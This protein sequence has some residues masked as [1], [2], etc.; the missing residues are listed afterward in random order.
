[1]CTLSA[2]GDDFFK[3]VEQIGHSH[4]GRKLLHPLTDNFQVGAGMSVEQ[5]FDIFI[6][7]LTPPQLEVS[8]AQLFKT[9]TV[10]FWSEQ[11]RDLGVGVQRLNSLSGVRAASL[12]DPEAARTIR[13]VR[14]VAHP[15]GRTVEHI[16]PTAIAL[17]SASSPVT[18][19]E[20]ASAAITRNT[21][22]RACGSEHIQ[23]GRPPPRAETP[24]HHCRLASGTIAD[25]ADDDRA[26]RS[27]EESDSEGSEREQQAMGRLCGRKE[28]M[29]DL[30]GEVGIRQEVVELKRVAVA[31]HEHLAQ[32]HVLCLGIEQVRWAR[33]NHDQRTVIFRL[34]RG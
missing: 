9:Q 10:A 30:N 11:L 23:T 24:G 27:R 26:Q 20:R 12:A 21:T 31:N 16:D 1:M 34:S 33:G 22:S 18:R 8:L 13:F 29:S 7:A 5:P 14:D 19:E 15:L 28:T 4:P 32:R 25:S 2:A 17:E 6:G 3:I